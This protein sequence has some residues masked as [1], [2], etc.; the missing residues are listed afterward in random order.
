MPRVAERNA[1]ALEVVYFPRKVTV[2]GET[3][4]AVPECV[5]AFL[6]FMNAR[7]S[8]SGEPLEVLE[9]ALDVLGEEFKTHAQ[10]SSRWGLAKSTGGTQAQPERLNL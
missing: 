4:D 7:G 3:L 10:D 9:Q 5:K 2:D 1:A 6:A 8:L